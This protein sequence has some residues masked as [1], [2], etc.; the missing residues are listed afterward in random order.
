MAVETEILPERYRS[1]RTVAHGGM[2]E[3]YRATDETLGREV[4]VKVLAERYARDPAL[5]ARFTREALAAARLSGE[6]YIVTI[7]DVGERDDR[8]YIVMEFLPGGTV[9]DRI[10]AGRVDPARALD[11]LEQAGAALDAAHAKGIV[12]RDVKPQNL[13]LAADGTVRVA[14]FGIASATGLASLTATG[15]VLGTL[16]YL[17]PEQALGQGTSPAADRYA[18]AVVAYEL[19]TGTRPFAGGN[20]P[21]EAAAAAREPVP[22]ISRGRGDLPSSLDPVFER[23]LAKD[24]QARY[25]T[26]AEFVGDVRRAFADAA[27]TTRVVPAPVAKRRR[28]WLL[29]A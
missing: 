6:P 25:P 17:A 3:I 2:G 15:T 18:L 12:H 8:P 28:P 9:G 29:P 7:Y 20:G 21:A 26:C 10:A 4:A 24:P 13:L 1:L 19:L 14:D 22:Q 5:R 16:G 23:A 27:G 11:W